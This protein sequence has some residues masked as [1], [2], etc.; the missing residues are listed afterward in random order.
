MP[1]RGNDNSGHRTTPRY[2]KLS[3]EERK[4]LPFPLNEKDARLTLERQSGRNGVGFYWKPWSSTS[5]DTYE[6]VSIVA[7]A[8][9]PTAVIESVPY[10]FHE[11]G[12]IDQSGKR[13]PTR[14]VQYTNGS[15]TNINLSPS[16]SHYERIYIRTSYITKAKLIIT[17]V[18]KII[19]TVIS[20][21][22]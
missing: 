9:S 20:S 8:T 14:K 5:P 12:T 22:N 11:S 15:L 3:P 19:D 2:D 21:V 18:Q 16:S 17:R 6:E 10:Y 7:P 4:R 13:I 1:I